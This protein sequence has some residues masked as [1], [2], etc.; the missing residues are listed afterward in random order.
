MKR[1]SEPT[2][3]R[4]SMTG[5]LRVSSAADVFGAEAPRHL[6]IDLHRSAL[7]RAA[8]RVLQV[9]F[10]LRPVERAFARQFGPFDTAGAKRVAQCVLG[11]IPRRIVAEALVGAQRELDGDRL[12]SEHPIDVE[13]QLVERGHLGFDLRLGAEDVAVVLGEAAHAHDAVQCARRLVAM[14][15]AEL[16]VAQRQVAVAAQIRVEDQHVSRTVHRLDRVVALLGLR[17]EH[18]VLEVLPVP[19]LLP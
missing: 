10:D 14:A 15:R 13:R 6:E 12:E 5:T 17:R 19:G 3:A 2:I 16:A 18:V 1:S 9:V 7:P 4:C 8:D 11:A